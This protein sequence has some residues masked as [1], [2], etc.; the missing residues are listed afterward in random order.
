MSG[1][2][3]GKTANV[4]DLFAGTGGMGL[5]SLLA[6]HLRGRARIIHCGELNG[7]Y[8]S[9]IRANYT[10]FAERIGSAEQVP[11][12][13]YAADVTSRGYLQALNHLRV[14][15]GIE[16]LLAGP[17]CQG[18]SRSNSISCKSV[19][20]LNLLALDTVN[21]IQAAL[22]AI[23]IIENV[24]GIQSMESAKNARFSVSAHI[25]RLL[26]RSGYKTATKLL[27]AA[28]YGV[29]QHR[30][31]S[32]TIA[33]HRRL[34]DQID[35]QNLIP[36]K[37]FG[38]GTG[39]PHRTV[40]EAFGDLPLLGNGSTQFISDYSVPPRT[41]LQREFRQFS[42]RLYDHVTTNH[43]EYVLDRYSEIPAGG[44]WKSIEDQLYNYAKPENTH[45]NIY[46]RLD[47]K[48]PS[49]TIGNF[50][51]AMTIHPFENRG[52]SLREA[53]RL[54]SLPDWLRFFPDDAELH[55]GQLKGLGLKQQQVGNAVCFRLTSRIVN[56]LFADA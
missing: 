49:K 52:L 21:L 44:N 55:R 36:T 47:P 43:A 24:P 30:L 29:P 41:S 22:P 13:I 56:H 32:F 35:C 9:S 23:A 20:P 11:G 48:K 3:H 5:A 28:D 2:L 26:C 33:V 45:M 25:E 31:R 18:F 14:S 27:D 42:K 15:E 16:L 46:H 12:R 51:K 10:Y 50:R 1:W 38:D 34:W 37:S 19:N 40:A 6:T 7:S 17:P 39:R 53:A 54:Q 4:V 8:V